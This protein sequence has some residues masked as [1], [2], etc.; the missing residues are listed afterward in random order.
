MGNTALHFAAG[1]GHNESVTFLLT[2]GCSLDVINKVS[3]TDI[4]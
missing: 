4:A 2:N 1:S 3:A